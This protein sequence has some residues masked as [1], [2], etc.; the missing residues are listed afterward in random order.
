MGMK[1]KELIA[2]LSVVDPESDILVSTVSYKERNHYEAGY[3]RER[4]QKTNGV[5]IQNG[6]IVINGGKERRV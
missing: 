5:S 3:E 4:P 6:A 2:I 1:A